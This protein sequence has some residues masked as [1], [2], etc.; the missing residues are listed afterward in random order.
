M[1]AAYQ[2]STIHP[3]PKLG[4]IALQNAKNAQLARMVNADV[5]KK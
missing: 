2:A 4:T 5:F 3:A 1:A